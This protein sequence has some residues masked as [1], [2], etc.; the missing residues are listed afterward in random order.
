M[1]S[2]TE[3]ECEDETICSTNNDTVQEHVLYCTKKR[4]LMY[5]VS[6]SLIVGHIAP[7]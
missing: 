1:K 2:H 7:R 5:A 3:F 4:Y 6:D